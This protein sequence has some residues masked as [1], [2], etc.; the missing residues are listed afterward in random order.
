[1]LQTAAEKTT[2]Q[3]QQ[4]YSEVSSKLDELNRTLNDFDATKKKLA[5]ENGDLVRQLEEAENNLSQLSRVR[6]SLTNQLDDT[7]KLADEES[8]VSSAKIP[9]RIKALNI[10]CNNIFSDSVNHG[11]MCFCLI[12]Q[13]HATLLGKFRNLEHDIETLREQLEE[14]SEAKA[15]VQRMLSKANAETLMWRSKYESEGVARVEEIEASRMKLAAR[16]EEAE[17]QIESLNV[18][19]LHLEKTKMRA[20]AELEELQVSAERAQTMAASAEKKQKNFDK[21]IS[22]WKMKIE[23][24]TAELDASQ[25]ECRNYSTENF[26]LKTADEEITEQLDCIRRENKNLNDEIKDLIDQI[27]EGGRA[28]HEVQKNMKR[29]ELEKE[30]L[31]TALEEAEAALEQEENKVLRTQLELGQVRQ[32]VDR[33]VQE[34][35][36]EFDN[37]R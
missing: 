20:S 37:T 28:H 12:H 2:K 31:Q 26:R 35:E 5:C 18:K 9:R 8:R 7:R 36:E 13:A 15:G 14:E 22:E 19:N 25:K 32:E 33:R 27:G 1:M 10:Y 6:L 17:M 21:I 16:L 30:E 4:Q 34:K 24:L 29:L 3:L 11:F 23:D